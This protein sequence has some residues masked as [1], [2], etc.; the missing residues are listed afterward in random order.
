[1]A[2]VLQLEKKSVNLIFLGYEDVP[3]FVDYLLEFLL[4]LQDDLHFRQVVSFIEDDDG[5][6]FV[7]SADVQ[8]VVFS[9]VF[10]GLEQVNDLLGNLD[11][12]R[13]EHCVDEGE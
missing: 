8:A 3:L 5:V 1:M 7:Q 13:F 6:A 9:D 2:F 12:C 4:V 11:S 10:E